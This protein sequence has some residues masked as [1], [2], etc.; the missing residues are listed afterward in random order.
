MDPEANIREQVSLAEEIA[1]GMDE[2]GFDDFEGR[3]IRLAELVLALDE[4]NR[5]KQPLQ[6]SEPIG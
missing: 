2:R 5:K 3:A 4:W 6:E 1:N